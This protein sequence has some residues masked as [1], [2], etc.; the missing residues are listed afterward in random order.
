MHMYIWWDGMCQTNP[1][2]TKE[3]KIQQKLTC[4]GAYSGMV[5]LKGSIVSTII[6]FMSP[7]P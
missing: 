3:Y 5:W 6:I 7:L 4:P 2:V 1:Q